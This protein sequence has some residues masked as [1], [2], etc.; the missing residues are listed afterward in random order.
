MRLNE[1]TALSAASFSIDCPGINGTNDPGYT[2]LTAEGTP[3]T[4]SATP[5]VLPTDDAKSSAVAPGSTTAPEQSLTNIPGPS[6]A[7]LDP[8]PAHDPSS[9][10]SSFT[11]TSTSTPATLSPSQSSTTS[12]LTPSPSASRN[13][14]TSLQSSSSSSSSTSSPSPSPSPSST[15]AQ[16][17][18]SNNGSLSGRT[19]LILAIVFPIAGIVTLILGIWWIN[20]SKKPPPSKQE[21]DNTSS[22]PISA[23][24]PYPGQ[25]TAELDGDRGGE[26]DAR[27]NSGH[28]E[29]GSRALYEMADRREVKTT[30]MINEMGIQELT[31]DREHPREL[32]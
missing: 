25:S 21:P 22:T 13:P 4:T 30:G 32:D 18:T 19:K 5:V 24:L 20:H 10:P 15:P 27:P 8:S 31:G 17:G 2:T 28:H 23:H 29:L 16:Q 12:P 1:C 7:V 6:S 11:T 26:L 14:Q 3:S 9:A